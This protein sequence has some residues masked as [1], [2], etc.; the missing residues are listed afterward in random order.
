MEIGERKLQILQAII[1]DYL[2]NAEPVGSRSLAKRSRSAGAGTCPSTCPATS[3]SGPGPRT[4]TT[5][6]TGRRT[7]AAWSA[8]TCSAGWM[9]NWKYAARDAPT[10]ATDGYNGQMSVG[11]RRRR[12]G[13]GGLHPRRR[14][15]HRHRR[16]RRQGLRRPGPIDSAAR[17]VRLRI[18]VDTQSVEVFVDDGDYWSSVV[19]D[20][21][22]SCRALVMAMVSVGD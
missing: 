18:E 1:T 15:A 14:A 9:D 16:P 13:L 21:Y 17:R 19:C 11:R 12:R 5:S 4:S 10:D 3:W 6:W 8:P 22:D 20:R 2:K 7:W